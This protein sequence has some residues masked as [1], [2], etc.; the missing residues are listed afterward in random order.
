M[1]NET[2][3]QY[4]IIEKLGSGG[5]GEVYLAEDTRL[6]RRVALKFLPD[7]YINDDDLKTRFMREARAAAKLNHTN[8]V[9]IYEV[10]EH[11]GRPFIAMEYVEGESLQK[12]IKAGKLTISEAVNLTMQICEGLNEA[13]TAGVVHRDIKPGN[14]IIDKKR[15]PRLLDFGLATVTGEKTLTQ[16]GSTL[17]TIE[18]MS[19]EQVKGEKTDRRSDIFSLGVMFYQMIT[20][21]LPFKGD[22]VAGV[23]YSIINENPEPLSRYKSGIMGSLQQIIDKVL[24]KDPS[25]RYQ[26]ADEMLADLRRLQTETASAGKSRFG[27]WVAAAIIVV[28][29]G[30][31]GY[32]QLIK[33]EPK[34]SGPKRLVV[35]PF[36][37]MGES[38]KDYFVSGM[39]EEITSR[40]SNIKG[41]AVVSSATAN[42]YRDSEKST[43]QIGEELDTE[44]IVNG[45]VQWQEEPEGEKR[46]KITTHLIKTDDDVSIWSKTYDTVMTEIFSVQSDIA[47]NVS[48]QMGIKL[49]VIERKEVWERYTNSQEAYDFYLQGQRFSGRYGGF[50]SIIDY[51]LAAEM[52]NKAIALDSG[53]VRAYYSLSWSYN[54][55]WGR[56]DHSDS[57]KQKAL[58]A[59]KKTQE[60]APGT[61]M[62]GRAMANYY[63]KCLN[64]PKRA[65]EKL[66]E[67]YA[68][69]PENRLYLGASHNY[70]RA[71]GKWE[72]ALKRKRIYV[73]KNPKRISGY[74]DLGQDC[75]YLR[76]YEEAEKHFDKVIEMQPD[77]FT[78]YYRK[79]ELYLNWMGDIGKAREAMRQSYGK[80]DSTRWRSTQRWLDVM[81][82][83]FDLALSRVSIP[84]YDSLYYYLLKGAIYR[85]M[86]RPDMMRVYFDSA[87]VH[88]E[89]FLLENP[90]DADAHSYMGIVCAGLGRK[91]EAIREGKKAIE[92]APIEKDAFDKYDYLDYLLLI[93]IQLN[94]QEEALKILDD[95]L[96]LHTNKDLPLVLI[97][98]EYAPMLDYPGFDKIVEKYGNEYAR[99]LWD[100]HQSKSI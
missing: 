79:V 44:F 36:K 86:R 60:L 5:M 65:L 85:C 66:D 29:G 95:I 49:D 53:F 76:L 54:M 23:I 43:R 28:V 61:K 26:H 3:F 64:D 55:Q 12:V 74:F 9:T 22:F 97:D 68:D 32:S 46:F 34:P 98:P 25:L 100:K 56:G 92:L 18:Y 52:Y 27:L 11:K 59:A 50:G 94:E 67:T 16:T 87:F 6:N 39:T 15:S 48:T 70:L 24:S 58:W 2:V 51:R 71:M 35:L 77:F 45:S 33:E 88:V 96:S 90:D 80:V 4:R 57:V 42:R 82:G 69:D 37:N 62:A 20:G 14:I 73:E 21:Q 81:E 38:N 30:Y 72:E 1:I 75:L 41:L 47:E 89:K 78:A 63:F 91:N 13:H 84:P 19:P 8:I 83:K 7:Q 10:N 99:D 17:G 40:L 31:F 93:Y